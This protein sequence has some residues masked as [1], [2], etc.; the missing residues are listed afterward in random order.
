MAEL[1]R[2]VE[3]QNADAAFES[4]L[5][6]IRA[7]R[8]TSHWIWFVFPQL[9]G[10]GTSPTSRFYALDG[11]GEAE[12]YLRHPVLGP[13]LLAITTAVVEHLRAGRHLEALMGSRIDAAKTVSSMTLFAEVVGDDGREVAHDG[14]TVG[15]IVARGNVVM[16]G[17]FNDPEATAKAI[18]GGW[19]HSGDAA[20]VHPDGYIEIRDRIKDVIKSGGENISSIEIEGVM[21]G[22]AAIQEVAVVGIPDVKWGESP[23]A[24]VVLR[25]G[26][27]VD[28]PALSEYVRS[29]LAH[30]K[31]PTAY[32]F[33]N[34]LPKT[35]TCKVQ[36]FVLR[37]GRS[38]VSAQ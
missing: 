24:F 2:F 37:G 25:R 27:S 10:L 26:A 3:A 8:K 1:E 19:F 35:A 21:L 31:C 7:G 16:K 18:R 13:R 29:R 23:H 6:E 4:A 5:A 22:H 15:E 28:A 12:R 20:V 33:V 11:R 34:E 36:K 17:Y 9:A 38:A 14:E 32:H 30:F